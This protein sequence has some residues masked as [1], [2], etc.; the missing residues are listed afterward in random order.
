MDKQ[1]HALFTGETGSGNPTLIHAI[2][3]TLIQFKKPE[4]FGLC[5]EI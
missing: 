2:I 1:P 5:L 4:E 3:T